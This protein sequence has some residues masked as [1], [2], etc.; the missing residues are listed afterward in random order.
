MIETS[1]KNYTEI[2]KKLYNIG[3]NLNENLET[4][5]KQKFKDI[6]LKIQDL[7]FNIQKQIILEE[8]L[9][10]RGKR[11]QIDDITVLGLEFLIEN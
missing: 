6:L 11:E 7:D 8:F 10:F 3:K 5:G 4:F 9:M 2:Y 1:I